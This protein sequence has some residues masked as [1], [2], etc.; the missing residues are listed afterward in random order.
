MSSIEKPPRRQASRITFSRRAMRVRRRRNRRGGGFRYDHRPVAVRVDQ[1]ARRD[2]HAGDGHR[3]VESGDIRMDVRR[4]DGTGEDE[5]ALGHLVDVAH[6]AIGDH[7]GATERLV[8]VGLD[9]A[10][11]RAD[12][13]L[14]VGV[15][16]NDD[17]RA[18]TFLDVIIVGE[19]A[20]ALV[21]ARRRRAATDDGGPGKADHRL[22]LGEGTDQ[23]PAVEA[24]GAP[25]AG[26]R[27]RAH[28]RSSACRYPA[29]FQSGRWKWSSLRRR[30]PAEPVSHNLPNSYIS[31]QE[32]PLVGCRLPRQRLF[33]DQRSAMT[34]R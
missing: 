17:A 1:V 16:D 7:A 22:Q 32:N 11:E 4:H 25:R 13:L 14:G 18:R 28:C 8:N 15:L 2:R 9:L 30:S 33:P 31:C 34:D 6:R 29:A 23:R 27:S 12:P 24:R 5:E 3:H 19:P 10:P 26:R 21:G 20:T